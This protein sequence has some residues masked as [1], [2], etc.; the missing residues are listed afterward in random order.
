MQT[1]LRMPRCHVR[2]QTF[3]IFLRRDFDFRHPLDRTRL[4]HAMIHRRTRHVE[5][6][7][8]EPRSPYRTPRA[9]CRQSLSL[10]TCHGSSAAA[11]AGRS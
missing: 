5:R 4:F 11:A 9:P 2:P 8:G 6:L 1:S 3:I 7:R 10:A